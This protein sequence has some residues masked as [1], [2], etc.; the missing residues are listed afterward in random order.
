MRKNP[1]NCKENMEYQGAGN[2]RQR[3]QISVTV[4]LIQLP[5]CYRFNCR[6]VA[7]KGRAILVSTA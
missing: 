6:C 5:S 7:L 1:T 3:T 4:H 2:F